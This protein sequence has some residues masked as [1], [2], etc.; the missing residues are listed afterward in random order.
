MP[1]LSGVTRD[2]NSVVD[3]TIYE[4]PDKS[5]IV[6]GRESSEIPENLFGCSVFE[7]LPHLIKKSCDLVPS[8]LRK[9]VF[10]T[11]VIAG[12]AIT[13]RFF[14]DRLNKELFESD[15]E[16][17]QNYKTK[18]NQ[19]N[20]KTEA[21]CSSWIAASVISAMSTFDQMQILRSEYQEHGY[22]LIDR[23]FT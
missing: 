6:V 22:G 20:G 17:F 16:F 9:E 12:G 1:L 4:L 10:G 13:T 21:R 18:F 19:C 11:F 14:Y 23:K 3:N 15:N 2:F 5:T 7:G 8:E